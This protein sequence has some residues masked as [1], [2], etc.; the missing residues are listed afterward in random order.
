MRKRL[1]TMILIIFAASLFAEGTQ[2]S[3]GQT[4]PRKDQSAS[5]E[6]EVGT[7]LVSDDLMIGES[8]GKIE[9]EAAGSVKNTYEGTINI[10]NMLTGSQALPGSRGDTYLDFLRSNVETIAKALASE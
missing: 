1:F 4:M 2:E 3:G 8:A 6:R 9:I 7:P 10:V 5:S